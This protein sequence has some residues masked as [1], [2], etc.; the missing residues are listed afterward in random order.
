MTWQGAGLR[1]RSEILEPVVALHTPSLNSGRPAQSKLQAND[2]SGGL[3][4][5]PPPLGCEPIN[6]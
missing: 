5:L 4:I 2:R 6:Q 3:A 1:E